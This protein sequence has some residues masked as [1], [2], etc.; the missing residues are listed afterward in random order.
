[1]YHGLKVLQNRVEHSKLFVY[2][3]GKKALLEKDG[4]LLYCETLF[5]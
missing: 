2:S 1:M 5:C 4:K 3:L